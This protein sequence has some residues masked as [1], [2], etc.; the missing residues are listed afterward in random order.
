MPAPRRGPQQLIEDCQGLVRSLAARIRRKLPSSIDLE[1]LIAYGQIGLAEAARD[2]D[3]TRGIEFSTYAYYRIRGAI[4]DGLSKMT[5]GNRSHYNQVRYQQLA[6]DLLRLETEDDTGGQQRGIESE[7]RWLRDVSRALAVIY[8]S[9]HHSDDDIAGQH[10]LEDRSTLA[11]P[12]VAI[13]RE[14]K[15]KLRELID[16]L[17]SEA[18][19]LS[20]GVYFEG[21]TLQ[22]AGERIGVSKS[23][24]SRLHAKTLQRLARS[25]KLLGVAS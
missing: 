25:L 11:P 18:G 21:L 16:A 7:G 22:E 9:T 4:Y 13:Q 12:A 3:P 24:A 8:L 19:V 14:L 10:P 17:P 6:N 2:F 20:R 5:W 15:Q 23:W 1:D